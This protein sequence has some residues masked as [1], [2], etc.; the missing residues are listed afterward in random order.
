MT[1]MATR[2]RLIMFCL[3]AG[4]FFQPLV[5]GNRCDQPV[6]IKADFSDTSIST[7]KT[8][9]RGNVNISQCD[10]EI[11]AEEALILT[12]DRQIQSVELT[13]NPVR[14][15]QNSGSLGQLNATA[16]TVNYDVAGAVMVFTGNVYIKHSQGEVH[17]E[18][19]RYEMLND[20]FQG[21]GDEN[22]GRIQ[23]R[24]DA[25]AQLLNTQATDPEDS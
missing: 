24:L 25:P 10:L 17:G 15:D 4:G 3:L 22:D 7:G 20:R 21:G 23:I 5:A 16:D 18:Q 1:V 19:I 11:Y 13:G 9:L 12:S 2:I 14:V 6:N 8:V